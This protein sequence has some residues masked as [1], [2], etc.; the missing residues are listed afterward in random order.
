M[1]GFLQTPKC[2]NYYLSIIGSTA[3]PLKNGYQRTMTKIYSFQSFRTDAFSWQ[4]KWGD[5]G[6][7]IKENDQESIAWHLL[8]QCTPLSV[9]QSV[10]QWLVV[11]AIASSKFASLFLIWNVLK[12]GNYNITLF[13]LVRVW[14]WTWPWPRSW[15]WP[16]TKLNFSSA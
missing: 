8:A 9:S 10:S 14:A 16:K 6:W 13:L 12:R 3:T 1:F 5:R 7:R 11:S 2:K 4:H 15:L